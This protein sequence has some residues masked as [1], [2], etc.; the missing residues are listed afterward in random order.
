MSI[1]NRFLPY[2]IVLMTAA[3]AGI[4]ALQVFW[5]MQAYELKSREFDS[6][7]NM[8][9]I[10]TAER[11]EALETK[12]I[13]KSKIGPGVNYFPEYPDS[14][15]ATAIPSQAL[16]DQT[17]INIREP[18]AEA[19]ASQ[20]KIFLPDG[21][22]LTIS[23]NTIGG[24]LN[25]SM[26]A[27]VQVEARQLFTDI[28]LELEA[29]KNQGL[30]VA[31]PSMIDS[32]LSY[33]LYEYGIR[34]NYR[35]AVYLP[36]S[37][38]AILL[39][40]TKTFADLHDSPFYIRLF[41]QY[42]FADSQY[43][44]IDF[45]TKTASIIAELQTI[46]LLFL[47]FSAIIIGV[48]AYTLRNFIRQR[49]LSELKTDFINNMTHEFKTPIASI[50]LA[51]DSLKNPKIL[52]NP[53]LILRYG[54]I[55]KEENRRMNRHIEAVLQSAILE[56]DTLQLKREKLSL[57]T[58][59]ETA[60]DRVR[61]QNGEK[62]IRIAEEYEAAKDEVFGDEMHLVNVFVN[63]LENAVKYCPT[64]PE[65]IIKTHNEGQLLIISI[66]DNGIGIKKEDLKEVFQ[67]FYRVPTG[68]LH[69]VKGFGLGLHY[70]KSIVE[71]HGGDVKAESIFG[72]G[73]TFTV[74]LPLFKNEDND[75]EHNEQE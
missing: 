9:L 35:G 57:H 74:T 3:L 23:T 37:D 40:N 47:I 75:H 32:V 18:Q 12:S 54:E 59:M 72:K 55:I 50:S 48:Y 2:S 53:E 13:I 46:I 38:S 20:Q 65:I 45:S 5:F 29:F 25:D 28:L 21:T 30:T 42:M 10:K 68:N 19:E 52:Q 71:M 64:V 41:P 34:S 61:F 7:V 56:K 16:L 73:S 39:S 62:E 24:A 60:A 51:A 8:A 44:V 6:R 67:K 26:R 36:E 43:L 27:T 70:V 22:E 33:T 4:F 69:N 1:K 66:S 49:K 15:R 17:T 31:N 11:I 63:L 58:L 14:N